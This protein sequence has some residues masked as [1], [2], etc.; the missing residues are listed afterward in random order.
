MVDKFLECGP[1]T[2]LTH[3][4]DCLCHIKSFMRDTV[5]HGKTDSIILLTGPK[6]HGSRARVV[7]EMKLWLLCC[8]VAKVVLKLS[9]GETYFL[10]QNKAAPETQE[11]LF[12][13]RLSSPIILSVNPGY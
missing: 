9:L 7:G 6:G 1:E 8:A 4:R 10:R 2:P 13:H 3:N 11:P 5:G 12:L